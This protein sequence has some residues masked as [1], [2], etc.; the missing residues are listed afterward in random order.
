MKKKLIIV[1]LLIQII[2]IDSNHCHN[3]N[4]DKINNSYNNKSDD[5]NIY[6]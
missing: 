2:N 4:K 5:D 6:Y 3:S 1:L